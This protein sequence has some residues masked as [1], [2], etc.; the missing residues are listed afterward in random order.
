M[1]VV[2]EVVIVVGLFHQTGEV[3]VVVM[4]VPY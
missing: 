4:V 2:M 3:M 1:V